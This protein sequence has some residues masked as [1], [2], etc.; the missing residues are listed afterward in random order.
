[1]TQYDS[2]T[3]GEGTR[4][5]S[6]VSKRNARTQDYI[7]ANGLLLRGVVLNTWVLDDT[8]HPFITDGPVAIYCDVLCYSGPVSMRWRYL[9]QCLVS[10]E[11]G[12]MHRGNIWKPR[13]AKMDITGVP[14]D[15]E[16]GGNP[17]NW[18]GDH[19]LVGF[20]DDNLNQPV[21]L[22]GI[23]HPSADTGNIAKTLGHRMGLKLADGD[24]NF[25]KHHGSFF[26]VAQNGD[27]NVDTTLAYDGALP[28][29]TGQ[30]PL[31]SPIDGS[32]SQ[33][34]KLPQAATFQIQFINAGGT[35]SVAEFTLTKSQLKQVIQD[36][37]GDVLLQIGG[38]DTLKIEKNGATAKMTLGNG[39]K[40]VAIVEALQTLYT[41]LKGQLDTSDTHVHPTGT[42]PS[43]TP[44]PTISAPAWNTN[45]NSTHM[46]IP[47]V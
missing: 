37:L 40:H 42:G 38:G 23:P 4:L 45:I 29:P 7:R 19:V 24:P 28:T 46:E 34:Y 20:M 5:Q 3:V 22:R 14:I 15:P 30:E 27:W 11:I 33:H 1:M 26:G 44:N 8:A 16:K 31:V 2:I 18:D 17:A 32:G 25:W 6:A 47:D 9:P 41:T 10:Q 21:I 39:V 43:G 35:P 13:A 12:G 36:S